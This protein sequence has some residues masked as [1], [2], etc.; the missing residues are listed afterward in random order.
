MDRFKDLLQR[1]VRRSAPSSR[2]DAQEVIKRYGVYH[3]DNIIPVPKKTGKDF[4][5]RLA[6]GEMG[7]LVKELVEIQ[8]SFPEIF[9]TR[10]TVSRIEN[11]TQKI[12]DIEKVS[13]FWLDTLQQAHDQGGIEAQSVG[14][15]H[16]WNVGASLL[17]TEAIDRREAIVKELA[18][19]EEFPPRKRDAQL[20]RFIW[21]IG[22][23]K[24]NDVALRDFLGFKPGKQSPT[25][26]YKFLVDGTVISEYGRHREVYAEN[27]EPPNDE[28]PHATMQTIDVLGNSVLSVEG[29]ALSDLGRVFTISLKATEAPAIMS[30]IGAKSKQICDSVGEVQKASLRTVLNPKSKDLPEMAQAISSFLKRGDPLIDSRALAALGLGRTDKILDFSRQT[31]KLALGSSETDFYG[32]VN[33]TMDKMIEG[34]GGF[35]GVVTEEEVSDLL[36]DETKIDKEPT[37]T[38]MKKTVSEIF[39]KTRDSDLE[40]NPS[41]INWSGLPIPSETAITFEKTAPMKFR[42]LLRF[43]NEL[44]EDVLVRTR[45]DLSKDIFDWNLKYD[46][47]D[48]HEA[49]GDVRTF[50]SLLMVATGNVLD[51]IL[52]KTIASKVETKKAKRPTES[53]P[54]SPRER[55]QDPIYALRK[56]ARIGIVEPE[57][58]AINLGQAAIESSYRNFVDIP[59]DDELVQKLARLSTVDAAI[60]KAAIEEYNKKG[61]GGKFT[62]KRGRGKDGEPRFTLSVGCTVPKGVRVLLKESDSEANIRVFEIEDIRYRK[63]IYRANNL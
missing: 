61:T 13:P 39:S 28:F 35:M 60:V 33:N 52:A 47:N 49:P 51:S 32:S 9:A 54:K 53:S 12:W 30:E 19:D 34:L 50:R 41:E 25:P 57:Q 14:I 8:D 38:E 24:V 29:L 21:N 45:F 7:I 55:Y 44:G 48:L 42:L 6:K 17:A 36:G 26:Y 27:M 58:E 63:D 5:E 3:S 46:P 10:A 40:I 62:R 11:L 23:I 43:S 2:P 1:V 37:K 56:E 31:R 15:A 18:S 22:S 4:D 20:R 59:A 16:G